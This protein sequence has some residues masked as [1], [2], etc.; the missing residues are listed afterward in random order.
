MAA[1]SESFALRG[2]SWYDGHLQARPVATNA[3]TSGAISAISEVI[4]HILRNGLKSGV[5]MR[6]MLNQ[7]FM[8]F[9]ILGP[10]GSKWYPLMERVW[11]NWD[12]TKISTVL[13]KTATEQ[14]TYGPFL[15]LTFMTVI[16][17]LEGRSAAQ[18]RQAVATT[19]T[20][21]VVSNWCFWGPVN[22]VSYS[23]VPV[24]YRTVFAKLA[25]VFWMVYLIGTTSKSKPEK[26][27]VESEEAEDEKKKGS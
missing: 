5:S 3:V 7:I 23:Y 24:R 12:P 27:R 21:V 16:G 9:F 19:F 6:S 1:G 17:T 8:G 4:C 14:L 20:K 18:I 15:N 25:S 11:R 13:C 10:L 26:A 2:I 22:L